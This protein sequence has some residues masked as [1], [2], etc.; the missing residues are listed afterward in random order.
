MFD[1]EITVKGARLLFQNLFFDQEIDS[2]F[3]IEMQL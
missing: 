1:I 3:I 2:W